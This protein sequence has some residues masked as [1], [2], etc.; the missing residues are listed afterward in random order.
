LIQE[1]GLKV[2]FIMLFFHITKQVDFTA[3]STVCKEAH[4]DPMPIQEHTL[5]ALEMGPSTNAKQTI[6]WLHGL[7]ADGHD[8]APIA[9]KLALPTQAATRFI[10]PHAPTMPITL[11]KGYIMPA[12]Y[13]IYGVDL[14]AKI[15][16]VGI[17]RSVSQISALIQTEVARGMAPEHIFLGGFSQGAAIALMTGLGHP[18]RLAGLIALSGYLPLVEKALQKA[19]SANKDVPIFMAH[20]TEDPIVPYAAGK[21]AHTALSSAGY[22]IA[23]HAYKMVHTVCEQEIQDLSVWL[24]SIDN[25]Y[26]HSKKRI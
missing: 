13:D 18:Q 16:E 8:F 22:P 5:H 25:G 12:W 26:A 23:W 20:G 17:R 7:G 1:D 19:S 15:D 2:S 6:I 3:R 24:Q 9:N 11:N 14:A 21:I 4:R 10:F